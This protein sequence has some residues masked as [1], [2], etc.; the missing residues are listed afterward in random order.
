MQIEE[1]QYELQVYKDS[2]QSHKTQLQDQVKSQASREKLAADKIKEL[3]HEKEDLEAQLAQLQ[4]AGSQ[5]AAPT[6]EPTGELAVNNEVVEK[7]EIAEAKLTQSVKKARD[8]F[9]LKM[10][11]VYEHKAT[12][13][14]AAGFFSW[15]GIVDNKREVALYEGW[16]EFRF[17]AAA[18]LFYR[19]YIDVSKNAPLRR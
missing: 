16:L 4:A 12:Q 10:N 6:A 8:N 17:E 9:L 7:L 5:T 11:A 18:R 15:K 1:L 19:T 14:V 3:Q 13:R 2:V